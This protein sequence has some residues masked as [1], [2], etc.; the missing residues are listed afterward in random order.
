MRTVIRPISES[1]VARLLGHMLVDPL[2]LMGL[3]KGIGNQTGIEKLKLGY[4][5]CLFIVGAVQ[6]LWPIE[7]ADF[8]ISKE[9]KN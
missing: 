3:L 9:L 2:I 8:S 4:L 5:T 6:A 1:Y 7:H